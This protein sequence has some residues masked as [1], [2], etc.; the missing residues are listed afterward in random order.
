MINR[1]QELGGWPLAT[2][3]EILADEPDA[4]TTD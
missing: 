4:G 1:W 2:T 3:D